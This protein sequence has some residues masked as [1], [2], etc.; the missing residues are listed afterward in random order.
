MSNAMSQTKTKTEL[1]HDNA[2]KCQEAD[3]DSFSTGAKHIRT[4]DITLNI[5][6]QFGT[7]HSFEKGTKTRGSRTPFALQRQFRRPLPDCLGSTL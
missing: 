1:E 6:L 2:A 7:E 4:L 3:A 5:T